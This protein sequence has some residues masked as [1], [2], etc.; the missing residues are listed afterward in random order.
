MK[1]NQGFTLVE[2]LVVIAIIAILASI[3]IPNVVKYIGKGRVTKAQAEIKSAEIAIV[4]LLA[5]AGLSRPA[6]LFQPNFMGQF[7]VES[8]LQAE[9]IYTT[10]FYDLLRNGKNARFDELNG[11]V[12]RDGVIE[13][14]GNQ[15]MDIQPDPWGNLYRFY[16]GPWKPLNLDLPRGERPNRAL[17]DAKNPFRIYRADTS[18]PGGPLWDGSRDLEGKDVGYFASSDY[19]IYIYSFGQNLVSGQAIY[20][21]L[22]PDFDASNVDPQDLFGDHSGRGP[23]LTGYSVNQL[24]EE[25]GGHD[26]INNW[27]SGASWNFAQ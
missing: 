14:L 4:D 6:Q 17:N 22:H 11:V 27:D 23:I 20:E 1:R 24:P 16:A 7:G 21:P 18:V 15:Y 2:L 12:L 25:R 3:T 13:K 8:H 5:D 10:A 9:Q 19:P 26:D